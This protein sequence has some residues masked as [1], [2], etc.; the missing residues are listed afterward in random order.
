MYQELQIFEESFDNLFPVWGTEANDLSLPTLAV[1]DVFDHTGLPGIRW[2]KPPE[3]EQ[4][5][6][7]IAIRH[8]FSATGQGPEVDYVLQV[9]VALDA[10]ADGQQAALIDAEEDLQRQTGRADYLQSVAREQARRTAP[11]VLNKVVD[12]IESEMKSTPAHGIESEALNAWDEAAAILQADGHALTEMLRAE[13]E[14]SV[15][16]AFKHLTDGDRLAVWLAYADVT[17]CFFGRDWPEVHAGFDPQTV[18]DATMREIDEEV[19]GRITNML[20]AHEL[21]P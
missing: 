10:L 11:D 5:F 1:G 9:A 16:R 18:W 15:R 8:A 13:I 2:C 4:Q 14:S 3:A 7:V 21:Q 6:K 19:S 20:Y 17:E 12:G